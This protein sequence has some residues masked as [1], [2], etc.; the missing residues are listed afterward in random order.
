MAR[1]S[2]LLMSV[3]RGSVGGLTYTANQFHQIVMRARTSPVNPST[4]AQSS[5]RLGM[6]AANEQWD[7]LTDPERQAWEDYANSVTF[8]GPLGNYTVPG[9]QM[10]LGQQV[11]AYYLSYQ[12]YSDFDVPA[13]DPPL[14]LGLLG[15]GPIVP[16]V[17][18]TTGTGFQFGITNPNTEDITV[19]AWISHR[20]NDSR[21]RYKGPWYDPYFHAFEIL[22]SSAGNFVIDDLPTDGIYFVKLKAISTNTPRRLSPSA[23]Y[24]MEATTVA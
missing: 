3:I 8:S 21:L 2:S 13:M 12:E 1:A 20:Q 24:R 11:L 22:L 6:S 9:R 16:A 7:Q 15:L 14:K 18:G 4:Q 5:V 19:G 23:I 10:A 17:L